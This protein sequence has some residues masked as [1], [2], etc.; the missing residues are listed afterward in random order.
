M[1]N[2]VE[3]K[4]EVVVLVFKE[5]VGDEISCGGNNGNGNGNGGGNEKEDM[6]GFYVFVMEND[7]VGDDFVVFDFVEVVDD[8]IVEKDFKE[9]EVL[10]FEEGKVE[11]ISS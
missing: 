2:V 1:E 5:D 3:N 8:V 10:S 4:Q 6:D 9:G 11:V 7:I